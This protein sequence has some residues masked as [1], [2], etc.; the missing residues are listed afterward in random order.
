MI[1]DHLNHAALY[2]NLHPRFAPSFDFI[3]QVAAAPD[4]FPDGRRELQGLDLYVLVERYSTETP[5]KR[6]FESHRR[7]IDIQVVISGHEVMGIAPTTRLTPSDEFILA[8]DIQFHKPLA[9]A[10]GAASAVAM[11]PGDWTILFPHDGHMP[12][13]H[14]GKSSEVLKVV[15]KILA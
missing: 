5:D 2:E 12:R 13:C 15:C 6:I 7:Y 14:L 4:K 9:F 1:F 3:R 8:R 10:D 11:G